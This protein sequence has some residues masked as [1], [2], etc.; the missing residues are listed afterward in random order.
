MKAQTIAGRLQVAVPRRGSRP[1]RAA[2]P[3]FS[4]LF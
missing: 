3:L 2:N 1:S 4:P